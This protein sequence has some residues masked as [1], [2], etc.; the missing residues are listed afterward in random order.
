MHCILI[1]VLI[2]TRTACFNAYLE[3]F[4]SH[5]WSKSFLWH[6]YIPH[7]AT[8]SLLNY[9]NILLNLKK[10]KVVTI[11]YSKY[12]V[13]SILGF[14]CYAKYKESNK[15]KFLLTSKRLVQ[16][17]LHLKSSC[18]KLRSATFFLTNL[19]YSQSIEMCD[20]FLTFLPKYKMDSYVDYIEDI[21]TK[22]IE[23]LFKG[24]TTEGIENI[25]S[26]I[27]PMFYSSG[28]YNITQQNPVWIFRN[29]T[30]IFFHDLYMDVTFMTAEQWVVP[31]PI[32][33]ELLSLSIDAEYDDF[34]FSGIHL[35]PWFASIQAKLLCYH[36][37]GYAKEMTDI[38]TGMSSFI[39]ENKVTSKSSCVYLNML[40]YCQIKAGHHRQSVKSISQSLRIF[41]SKYIK[42]ITKLPNSEQSYNLSIILLQGI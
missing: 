34:P 23:Q 15:T 16:K 6:S 37:M 39:T 2:S 40:A 21:L 8:K 30:N 28:N 4:S 12:L 26:E 35:D 7:N 29:F 19:K 13:R 17:S 36:S 24:K 41:P 27:L 33:C 14:L 5:V 1:Y 32:L 11:H 20:T 10:V 42:V 3:A 31:D 25:M 38:L 18:I 9:V 22:I